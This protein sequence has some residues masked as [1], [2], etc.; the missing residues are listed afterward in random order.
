MYM[1]YS[2]N[3]HLPKVR[4]KAVN[5]VIQGWGIRKVARHFGV[6]PSTVLRWQRR[7]TNYGMRPIPTESSRPHTHPRAL[8]K[9]WVDSIVSV[10]RERNRC[11]EVVHQ[12]LA[13]QGV[14][15][16][17]STVKRT[18][19]REGLLRQRSPWKKWHFSLT[20]PYAMNPGDLVEIDTIHIV[21]PDGSRWYVYT[22]IDVVSRWAYAEVSERIGAGRSAAF[23]RRAEC[24]APFT[25]K[26]LQSDHGPEFSTWFTSHVSALH[27]H[28]RVRKPNDNAHVERF[29]RTIQEECLHMV[30]PLRAAHTK[31]VRNYLTYYNGRRLH[32]G[33]NLKI[34]LEVLRSY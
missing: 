14:V 26:M 28:S 9:E 32:L 30:P 11:A 22:L 5:L 12:T 17:L 16:S 4:M 8:K 33:L 2:K 21:R 20:R 29:N 31:A 6:H 24:A 10:R 19:D 1:S 15:V 23:V 34:P 25:F 3:P 13:N 7:D 18:L 27:R